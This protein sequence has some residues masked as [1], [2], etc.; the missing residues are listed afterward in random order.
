MRQHRSAKRRGA[1]F[2]NDVLV[3][4]PVEPVATNP[5]VME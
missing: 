4:E 2:R 1:D 3:R 5:L